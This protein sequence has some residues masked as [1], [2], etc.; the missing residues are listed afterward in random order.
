MNFHQQRGALADSVGVVARVGAVGG[1]NFDQLGTGAR[2]HVGNAKGTAN[3]HQLAARDD[4][5]APR[6]QRAQRQQ[7]G[8][9]V[10]VDHGGGFSAG[11]LAQQC[12]DQVVAVA[13]PAAGQVVLQ[14]HRRS[15]CLHHRFD[16]LGRE[17][18]AAQV[19][20]QHRAAQV[21]HRTQLGGKAL[22]QRAAHRLGH[23][24]GCQARG[25]Q[26]TVLG[27]HRAAQLRQHRT[28]RLGAGGFAVRGLRRLQRRVLQ[29][30]V[31]G[32]QRG[33]LHGWASSSA[34]ATYSSGFGLAR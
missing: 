1:A 15:H 33:E 32:G 30:F 27:A 18:R 22:R 13:A 26:R 19:G 12:F 29:Q 2:H 4:D 17:Q 10:V 24:F 6:S 8:S 34:T 25:I 21:E 20:V 23:R 5:F 11:Q 3:L 31:H 7:H 28:N 16:G 14:I 9:C